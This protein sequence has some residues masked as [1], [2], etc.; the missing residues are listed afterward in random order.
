[1]EGYSPW[2]HKE[3]DT[4]EC[5]SMRTDRKSSGFDLGNRCPSESYSCTFVQN[6]SF[7]ESEQLGAILMVQGT[8]K[9]E[10][11]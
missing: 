8:V 2:G 7:A 5:L 4:T 10:N 6:K 3:L 1:M 9:Q 11:E